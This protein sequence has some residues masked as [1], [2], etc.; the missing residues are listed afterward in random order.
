MSITRRAGLITGLLAGIWVIIEAAFNLSATEYRQFTGYISLL[1]YFSGIFVC[2]Q[3]T[4]D[5]ELGGFID[6][7]TALRKGLITATIAAVVWT[8]LTLIG[9]LFV[10]GLQFSSNA[11]SEAQQTFQN[12]TIIK[13]IVLVIF[14]TAY[15]ILN[16]ILLGT[17][18]SLITSLVLKRTPPTNQA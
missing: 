9:S 12:A 17:F 4:R 3:R 10:P 8:F 14:S 11:S 2:I 15:S 5:K 16:L 13:K 1:I 6:F 18:F 7:K